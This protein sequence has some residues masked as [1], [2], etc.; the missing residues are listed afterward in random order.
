VVVSQ[1]LEPKS[2]VIHGLES[3]ELTVRQALSV[4]NDDVI[5]PMVLSKCTTIAQQ[6][7]ET[8][9][10]YIQAGYNYSFHENTRQHYRIGRVWF[11]YDVLYCLL[12][13]T[14]AT[15]RQDRQRG[16][17]RC[18]ISGVSPQIQVSGIHMHRRRRDER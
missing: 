18:W 2:R 10:K 12:Y 6:V 3:L 8:F 4:K 13:G 15:H 5:F 14:F 9:E 7:T 11:T 1:R 17:R 16:Q